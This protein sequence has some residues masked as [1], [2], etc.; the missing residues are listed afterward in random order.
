MAV[1][2][3][4]STDRNWRNTCTS[5]NPLLRDRE[6]ELE[7]SIYTL[8]MQMCKAVHRYMANRLTFQVKLPVKLLLENTNVILYQ[9]L[10]GTK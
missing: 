10:S 1:T 5:V 8:H 3:W 4:S 2:I 6:K 7:K 9:Q